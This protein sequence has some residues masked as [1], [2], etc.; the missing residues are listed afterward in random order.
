MMAQSRLIRSCRHGL[1]LIEL[2]VVLT[3]LIALAGLLVPMLP[4]MLTRAHTSTCSTNMGECIRAITDYQALYST[5]PNNWDALG[6]GTTIINYFAD[7]TAMPADRRWSW[8]QSRQRRVHP[9]TLTANE[10]T[11]LTGVGIT[12]VQA[13][14]TTPTGA[15]GSGTFDPTFNY[16]S[17]AMPT[18]IA[19]RPGRSWPGWTPRLP[20]PPR[21][22]TPAVSR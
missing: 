1:T 13:M 18:P 20:G 15:V 22:P 16:Y 12:T 7:G 17:A 3:I 11:A 6:D 2:V 8:H 9:L 4:S 19:V 21:R 14:A 5:Y 10:A